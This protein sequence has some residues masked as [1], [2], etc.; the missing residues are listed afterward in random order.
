VKTP[1]FISL[2]IAGLLAGQ[3]LY[4]QMPSIHDTVRIDDVVIKG[5][6]S[7]RAAGF[8]RTVID[9][10][11]SAYHK[12][13][14]VADLLNSASPLFV[15][16]YG[17][18]G[19]ATVSFRGTGASHTVVTWNGINLNSPMLGQSDF[20]LM[21]VIAADDITIY[22]GGSSLAAAQGGL[23][24]VVDIT[25]KP[26]WNEEL[27]SF[28]MTTSWGSFGRY[29]ASFRSRYGK[30]PWRFSS[31]MSYNSATNDF[32]YRN[33]YLTGNDQ[34]ERR[35][36]ASSLQ[37][38][39]LQEAWYR[40]DKSVT[41]FRM[42]LQEHD[43]DL[44]VAIN[45]SPE[46]HDENLSG[47]V[48][49]SML[50][51]DHFGKNITW[52]GTVAIIY[53][54]MLYRDRVT[55]ISSPSS[56]AR[57]STRISALWNSGKRSTLKG[58]ITSDFEAV[59]SENYPENILRNI[60]WLSIGTEYLAAPWVDLNIGLVVPAVDWNL[61]TPD[62]SA[63]S[64]I[65]PF[66][67][68]WLKIKSN[69]SSR[70]RVPS[71]NDLYWI[72]GGNESLKTERALSSEIAISANSNSG[73]NRSFNLQV[74]LFNNSI[75][76]MIQWQPGSSGYWIP[77]NTGLVRSR[78][79]ES[80]F[81]SKLATGKSS[82]LLSSGYSYTV[83][84]EKGSPFQNIYVPK[85]MANGS[86]RFARGLSA[87]GFS[88]RYTGRRYITAENN[89]YLPSNTVAEVWLS[90]D[91]PTRVGGFHSMLAVENLFNLNYQTIAYHPMPPRAFKLTLSWN[92]KKEK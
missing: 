51:H 61:Q 13:G 26:L 86:L 73:D 78:G 43:R 88:L 80:T 17:P 5:K 57:T 52:S 74:A 16:S 89:Q 62:F 38:N 46:S 32:K 15:K 77:M 56:F 81:S 4:S 27:V 64:A 30:G 67:A 12:N 39:I 7:L 33:N 42:W 85:H 29:S 75:T 87:S 35:L 76:D 18:G 65:M 82:V 83:S 59:T 8:I 60:T 66:N 84:T 50:T 71:M 28:D 55:A 19:I 22:Y 21:P 37:K 24:G 72:P 44:P 70:S 11:F 47:M 45:I 3:A 92:L 9:P 14:T 23:G 53:D 54:E 68:R 69:I 1:S 49:R 79:M 40:T 6:P 34:S 63:G 2:L 36:N 48:L 90:I 25:T 41:G 31:G 10:R 58:E 91:L 20:Q